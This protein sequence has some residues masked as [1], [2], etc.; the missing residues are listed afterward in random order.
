MVK[1]KSKKPLKSDKVI[2]GMKLVTSH[3]CEECKTPCAAGI[4]Y[5]ERMRLP[6]AVGN[7][8]PCILTKWSQ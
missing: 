2:K 8:I 4:R 7:G 5:R 6:G 3:V 1:S